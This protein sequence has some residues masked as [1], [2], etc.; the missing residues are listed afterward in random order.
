MSIETADLVTAVLLVIG[1][2]FM[3]VGAVGVVRMPDLFMRM[4]ATT[5]SVTLGVSFMLAAV[6]VHFNELGLGSRAIA[7]IVFVFITA[8]IAAHMIGRAG[9]ARQVELWHGTIADEL[10]GRYDPETGELISKPPVHHPER[11]PSDGTD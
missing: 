8:P 3:F 9:Y 6:A 4:S 5:K 2:F 7:T 1:A 10:R 11:L